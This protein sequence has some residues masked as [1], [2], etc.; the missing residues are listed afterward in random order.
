MSIL[1]ML[2]GR[3]DVMVIQS[4]LPFWLTQNLKNRR[5]S[6]SARDI[7]D[8]AG[9]LWVATSLVHTCVRSITISL[10][11]QRLFVWIG[12]VGVGRWWCAGGGVWWVL[13]REE[14]LHVMC[15]KIYR[16]YDLRPRPIFFNIHLE[17]NVDF[18]L[19]ATS[20]T[21][22]LVLHGMLGLFL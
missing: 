4:G 22:T 21:I 17:R 9:S 7:H 6:C 8:I 10:S 18:P 13:L 11:D 12:C 16:L 15:D 14:R 3:T 2:Q 20:C 5:G 19:P 1:L